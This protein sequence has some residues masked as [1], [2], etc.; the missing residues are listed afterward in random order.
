MSTVVKVKQ[1]SKAYGS[2]QV[3]H[4][5]SFELREGERICI[6]G[7]SGC[8]KST[9]LQI[10]AGLLR[11]DGGEVEMGGNLVEGGRHHVPPEKRP[12]NMVFQDYALWPHMT[13]RE[14]IEYGMKR[15]KI[16]PAARQ[17]R[18]TRLESLLRLEGLLDRMP[19]QLSGGQQQRVGI[20]RALATEPQ[21]LLMDEPLSNLDIKLR[22]DMR[23]ELAQL[24]GALS[25]A[26]L[27]VT[28]DTMEA[29]TLADRILV[30]RDGR[31][32]QLAAPQE[33]FERPATPWVARL[34]GYHNRLEG[35]VAP[36]APGAAAIGGSI[37]AGQWM[38]PAAAGQA[39][40][41]MLHPEAI[42]VSERAEDG[43]PNRL[44]VRVRQSI[45]E[46][47]RWRLILETADKQAV[48]AFGERGA[49]PGTELGLYLPPAR[50]ML[51]GESLS[52]S[53]E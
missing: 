50:T 18:L 24:L 34:M 14:N 7:P 51:Y 6:L 45:Y 38:T 2:Q 41:L 31:V 15:R 29:F 48:H 20:A 35:T 36:G 26:T 9:L 49:E 23:H 22:T 33:L 3:L 19:A 43:Q 4:P 13:V 25:I 21:V 1:V 47:E 16:A 11:A 44:A 32:D 17:P 28:H 5:L 37:V 53:D 12:V 27:Y 42:R 46:G 30:L 52:R 40:V 10:V 8:G 39:V